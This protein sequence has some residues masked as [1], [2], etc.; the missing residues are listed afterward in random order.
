[1]FGSPRRVSVAGDAGDDAGH[2]PLRVGGVGR[3][4]PQLVHH[5]DRPGAHG[6]DV[7]DDAADPGG[8]ALIGL[9]ER[10]V[11]VRLDLEGDRPA[12]TDVDDA[13]VLADPGQHLGP[14][15]VGGGLAEVGQV[16]LGRLVRAVLRPHHRVHRQ[17]GVGRPAAED[18]PDPGVLVVLQ[19][20]FPVRLR[21]HRGWP[22]RAARCPARPEV[23]QVDGADRIG[24]VQ[25][26]RRGRVRDLI[27]HR[28]SDLCGDADQSPAPR[29]TA[30]ARRRWAR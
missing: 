19:A 4:E 15:L 1:M 24:D 29:R 6:Q 3:A 25:Q 12:V 7:P 14:H 9:D 22:R 27:G 13:G 10:R 16:H 11:V 17:L 23:D 30:R 8:R 18:L 26:V 21:A 2:H 28:G 5:R 20:E